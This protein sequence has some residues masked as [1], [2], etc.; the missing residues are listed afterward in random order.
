MSEIVAEGI[1][2]AGRLEEYLKVYH[3]RPSG[4]ESAFVDECKIHFDGEGLHVTV[5]D[6][7][8]VAMIGPSHLSKRAFESYEAPGR[9]TIGL[10]LARLL[11][12]LKPADAG[13]LVHFGVDMETRRLKFEYGAADLEMGLID[14]ESIRSEPDVPDVEL[15]NWFIITGEQLSDA[16]E[17]ADLVSDFVNVRVDPDAGTVAFATQGDID[18]G[19]VEYEASDCFDSEFSEASESI[20]SLDYLRTLAEPIPSDA[21]LTVDVGDEF[22]MVLEWEGVDGHLSVR[23]TL[24][25]RIQSD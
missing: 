6:A 2:E 21:E 15:P 11:K 25:P 4:V 3:A 14:P 7:A 20:F 1:V 17:I 9:V 23:Q 22:P 5:C 12:F 18:S 16:L 10:N 8:A 24:A 13:T 19:A